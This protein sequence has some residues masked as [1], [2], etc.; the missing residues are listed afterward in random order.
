[1]CQR[2]DYDVKFPSCR[3]FTRI[4]S[5]AILLA[6]LRIATDHRNII[7]IRVFYLNCFLFNIKYIRRL[8][9]YWSNFHPFFHLQIKKHKKNILSSFI[10]SLCLVANSPAIGILRS[11][12]VVAFPDFVWFSPTASCCCSGNTV[13]VY[14]CVDP[15]KMKWIL[16]ILI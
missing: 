7:H 12:I 9:Q 14:L 1:M 8:I 3:L 5:I 6:H 2:V 10:F 13:H 4:K 11:T 16:F 15:Y